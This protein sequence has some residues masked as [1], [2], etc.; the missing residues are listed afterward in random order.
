MYIYST[1]FWTQVRNSEWKQKLKRFSM[2]KSN[3]ELYNYSLFQTFRQSP[4]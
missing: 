3:Q 1:Y 2:F 4:K